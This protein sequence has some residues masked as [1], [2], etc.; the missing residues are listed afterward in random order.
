MSVSD[1]HTAFNQS[2]AKKDTG[3]SFEH[4]L[5]ASI[6]IGALGVKRHETERYTVGDFAYTSGSLHPAEG[7]DRICVHPLFIRQ[8][9]DRHGIARLRQRG[10]KSVYP[11]GTGIDGMSDSEE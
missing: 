4:F 6:A 7:I 9:H 2:G 10:V 8:F 3:M 11:Y 5:R 1:L